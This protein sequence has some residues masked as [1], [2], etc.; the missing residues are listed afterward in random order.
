MFNVRENTGHVSYVI[1]IIGHVYVR[2][3]QDMFNVRENT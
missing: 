1:E 2:E 3:R